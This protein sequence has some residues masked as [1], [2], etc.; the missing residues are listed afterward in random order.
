[1]TLINTIIGEDFFKID[2]GKR[3]T[4]MLL[5]DF[6]DYNPI[7]SHTTLD[8]KSRAKKLASAFFIHSFTSDDLY[9]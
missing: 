8:K 2:V 5:L 3:V 1:M 6:Q 7:K 4:G 9:S